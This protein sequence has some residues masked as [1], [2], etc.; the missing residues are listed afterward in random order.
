[1][2]KNAI[3]FSSQGMLVK[4]KYASIKSMIFVIKLLIKLWIFKI[5]IMSWFY[6]LDNYLGFPKWY[7]TLFS[8]KNYGFIKVLRNKM[9]EVQKWP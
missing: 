4:C 2:K 8:V 3:L 6:L 1:M 5:F 7:K 9:N